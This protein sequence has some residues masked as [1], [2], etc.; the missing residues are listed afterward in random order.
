MQHK[1][2]HKLQ[3]QID[4]KVYFI[5]A[6]STNNYCNFCYNKQKLHT[7]IKMNCK[8]NLSMIQFDIYIRVQ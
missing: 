2:I 4:K 8:S 5:L 7:Y 3:I 6:V 1:I